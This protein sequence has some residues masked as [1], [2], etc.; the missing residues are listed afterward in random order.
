LTTDLSRISGS[1]VIARNT[2]FTYK[3]KPADV[4][5]LGRDLGIRFVIEGSV[6]RTDDRVLVNVQLVDA[7]SGA[8]LWADRFETDRSNLAEAQSEITDRLART[9]KAELI[10]A[11]G[12]RIEQ[13]KTRDLDASDL[14]MRGEALARK[15]YSAT[16]IEAAR[17]LYE[18]ALE[19]DPGSLNAK[20]HI[21]TAL[22]ISVSNNWSSSVQ[23]D[24]AHAEQLLLDALE[25]DPNSALAHL[26]MG[27]LR[28]VQ[29][30]M[31]EARVEL[32]TV[33]ALDR[34]NNVAFR[35]LG[36]ILVQMGQPDA[37]IPYI[38]KAIRLDPHDPYISSSYFFLGQCHLLLG[39][40]DEAIHLLRK[41]GAARPRFYGNH[42][43]LAGAL[44]LRGEVDEARAVLAEATK[45]K[46]DVNS[47]AA[48]R[49]SSR[50]FNNPPYWA[51][52]EKTMIVGLRRAGFPDE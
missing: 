2:A 49:A 12:R 9:L 27:V 10:G 18:D 41:S 24:E 1:F 13:E 52:I 35:N 47:L 39:E 29:N 22:V 6:R 26:N 25:R 7:E 11:T 31:P 20:L 17:R 46:P 37:A 36:F 23:Q 8:H 40:V 33:I 50:A 32:Q 14:I 34:N 44:G 51:L 15:A 38:Q 28:R 30:R 42:L 4:K 21:A 43:W 48:W 19:K 5:Q 16:N 3:N 45:L